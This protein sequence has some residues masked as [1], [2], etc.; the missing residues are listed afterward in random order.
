MQSPDVTGPYLKM[1][2]SVKEKT[3]NLLRWSEKYTK[4]DMVYLAHGG[5]W[6]TLGQAVSAASSFFIAI[7]FANLLPQ[8]SYGTYKYVLSVASILSLAVLPG[9]NTAVV[10]A[11][12]K[13]DEASII[14]ATKEKI[15]WGILGGLGSLAMALFYY[16]NK[17]FELSIIFLII[18]AFIPLMD[19][20]S[21]YDSYLQGKKYFEK[22]AKYS[23]WSQLIYLTAILIGIF[24]T[25]NI[26]VL[27]IFYFSTWTI[28][29]YIFYNRVIKKINNK[30]DPE[31]IKYGR[32]LTYLQ[33]FNSV[34]EQ[35]GKL[36]LFN[37]FGAK[38]L[39]IYAVAIAP[40]EQIVGLLKSSSVLIMPKFATQTYDTISK[41]IIKKTFKFIFV[42][43]C[44]TITYFFLA[45][46]LFKIIFPRY[47]PD[48][49]FYSQIYSLSLVGTAMIIP[50]TLFLAH[51]ETAKLYTQNIVVS[52]VKLILYILLSYKFGIM[53]LIIS[54]I[55][56]RLTSLLLSIRLSQ[57]S[58]R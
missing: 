6:L 47:F 42:A 50:K 51:K 57:K 49:V 4:T 46:L 33:I 24:L 36:I 7:A 8:E 58:T 38:E 18:S 35:A 44:I 48:A 30:A 40:T 13:G 27:I 41:N 54:V 21:I 32:H 10:R 37:F 20:F 22:S 14:I 2:K 19:S 55:A 56:A 5:F 29:R 25:K 52:S 15:K 11:I 53:G 34:S 39:A 3:Y 45:P 9:I 28:I 1:I 17:N 23:V 12:A 16:L 43:A 26:L 31:V